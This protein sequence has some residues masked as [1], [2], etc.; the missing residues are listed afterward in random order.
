VRVCV[1][2]WTCCMKRLC[3]R[4]WTEWGCPHRNT[5]Q[6]KKRCSPIWERYSHI[7]DRR[8][9]TNTHTHMHTPTHTQS[10][11]HTRKH[12]NTHRQSWKWLHLPLLHQN[13]QVLSCND[14]GCEQKRLC[15]LFWTSKVTAPWLRTTER[16]S[17]GS[18]HWLPTVYGISKRKKEY[19]YLDKGTIYW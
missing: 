17:T 19:W 14:N 12:T 5:F 16:I 18:L 8:M 2:S 4:W 7:W 13:R 15:T 6:V 11:T 10:H 3:T 1:C 9:D